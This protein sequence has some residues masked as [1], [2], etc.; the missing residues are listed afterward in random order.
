MTDL[1][2][3]PFC[4]SS[5]VKCMDDNV[6]CV[7]CADCGARGPCFDVYTEATW[8]DRQLHPALDELEAW[9]IWLK[10]QQ[11][12]IG[13][14]ELVNEVLDKLRELKSGAPEQK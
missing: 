8:N 6:G 3:C 14:F 12:F 7:R 1:K 13:G 10:E 11:A 2:R 5:D 4:G 9:L